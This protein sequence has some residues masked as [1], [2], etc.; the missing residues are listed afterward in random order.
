MIFNSLMTSFCETF[1][2]YYIT[3]SNSGKSELLSKKTGRR[4]VNFLLVVNLD[5][6]LYISNS[7]TM[8][9]FVCKFIQLTSAPRRNYQVFFMS[10]PST[11]MFVFSGEKD[12]RCMRDHEGYI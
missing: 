1:R 6:N 4:K 5:K 11:E 8:H 7:P 2:Q 3:Q 10:L 12:Y 9:V